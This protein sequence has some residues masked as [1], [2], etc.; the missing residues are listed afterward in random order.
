MDKASKL[1]GLT[2]QN[3][4][5]ERVPMTFAEFVAAVK[6]S[7]IR[8]LGFSNVHFLDGTFPCL[9]QPSLGLDTLSIESCTASKPLKFHEFLTQNCDVKNVILKNTK[10][11]GPEN[12]LIHLLKN[13]S[14]SVESFTL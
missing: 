11:E 14:T 3:C 1:E 12:H 7:S 8:K 9:C 4:E 10:T 5:A 6:L 13:P 2:I